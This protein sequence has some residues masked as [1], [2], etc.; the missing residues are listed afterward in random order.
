MR[1]TS[2]RIKEVTPQ[3]AKLVLGWGTVYR[4]VSMEPESY[5]NSAFYPQLDGKMSISFWAE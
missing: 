2:S 4:Q 1:Q 3:R 5:I